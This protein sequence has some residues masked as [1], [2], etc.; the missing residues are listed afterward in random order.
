VEVGVTPVEVK[1][2]WYGVYDVLI[3][4]DGFE[5]LSTKAKTKTPLHAAPGFDIIA[6]VWPS[7]IKDHV[8]WHFELTPT[9]YDPDGVLERARTMRDEVFEVE[10]I[11]PSAPP[12]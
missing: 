3:E 1:Y 8:Y 10:V 12:Q 7:T 5:P 4:K 6:G 11:E 2:T 9:E